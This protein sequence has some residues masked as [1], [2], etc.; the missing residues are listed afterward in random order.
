MEVG[1]GNLLDFSWLE[2]ISKFSWSNVFEHEF[3][4]F[5]IRLL[6]LPSA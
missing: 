1:T 3:G 5:L 4:C 6:P 2:G